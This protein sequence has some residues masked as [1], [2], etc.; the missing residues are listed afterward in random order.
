MYSFDI[1]SLTKGGQQLVVCTTMAAS[2]HDAR[3]NVARFCW[4]QDITIHAIRRTA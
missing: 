2:K 4:A 1:I 3:R